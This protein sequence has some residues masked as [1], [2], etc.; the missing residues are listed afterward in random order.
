MNVKL[1][2]EAIRN[3][4]VFIKYTGVQPKD[5]ID[6]GEYIYFV[7]DGERMLEALGREAKNVRALSNALK[8][9]VKLLPYY[10]EPEDMVRAMIP[11]ARDIRQENGGYIVMVPFSERARVIGKNG[12]NIK[13]MKAVMKRHFGIVDL[14]VRA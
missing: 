2:T 6:Q 5:C 13:A 10:R 3:M 14:K 9:K 4:A 12:S 8:K 1:H 7:V 11:Q